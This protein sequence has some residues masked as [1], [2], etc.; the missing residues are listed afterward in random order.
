[1]VRFLASWHPVDT[2]AGVYVDLEKRVAHIDIEA[3]I[4]FLTQLENRPPL[5]LEARRWFACKAMRELR[6]GSVLA[7]GWT[8]VS[9]FKA[10]KW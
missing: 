5:P 7:D 2:V 3:R 4:D 9:H 8:L 6:E 1:V 10:E